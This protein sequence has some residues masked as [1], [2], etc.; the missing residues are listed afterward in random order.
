MNGLDTAQKLLFKLVEENPEDWAIR[1]RV[2]GLLE[3]SEMYEDASK[4]LWSAP[5]VPQIPVEVAYTIRVVSK[6]QPTRAVRF[7]EAIVAQYSSAPAVMVEIAKE[8]VKVGII[9]QAIRVYGAAAAVDKSVADQEFELCLIEVDSDK[10]NWNNFVN[11]EN[12]PWDA[13]VVD[14]GEVEE[15]EEEDFSALLSGGTMPVP[16]KALSA[17]IY[18]KQQPVAENK[19]PTVEAKA[20]IPE[21]KVEKKVGSE[22]ML[23]VLPD[24][25]VAKPE[26]LPVPPSEA[27]VRPK[28]EVVAERAKEEVRPQVI[29]PFKAS[30]E[31]PQ[32]ASPF[33]ASAEKPQVVSPFTASAE[34][35]VIAKSPKP[36]LSV[37]SN[38]LAQLPV[39][40]G[41]L[42]SLV[43][44]F[45][46]KSKQ[47]EADRVDVDSL[48]LSGVAP[49]PSP[50]F[51][52]VNNKIPLT[53]AA[54]SEKSPYV[55]AERRAKIS[56]SEH[57]LS[58]VST[59]IAQKV[60]RRV[61]KESNGPDVLD[62]RTQLVSLAPEDGTIFFEELA[63]KYK[64]VT[65]ANL[66]K[67][68]IIA[69]DMA[70][71]DYLD[72]VSKA[73]KKDLLAF[74]KLLGLHRVMSEANCTDWVADMNALR[75]GFGDAV[76]ATVVSKYS[77]NEC[78]EILNSVYAFP[79]SAA[80]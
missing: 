6:G 55:R 33:K 17:Q 28:P 15:E 47:V 48:D 78:K 71:L 22:T 36:N 45:R 63:L 25:V 7:V 23:K 43:N 8:L 54:T 26:L 12:F 70:N 61:T 16:I 69:R 37:V 3:E 20:V 40:S 62:G 50:S 60:E 4:M 65:S 34:K 73:C 67:P 59:A 64:N 9:H 5:D 46:G 27:Q 32:V 76:L 1:K 49:S 18:N 68:S 29:S 10:R 74:S 77:V 21:S 75:K 30:A 2:V 52:P 44:R 31:K 11:T 79:S 24:A 38:K 56:S 19:V 66:P 42:A 14:T 35:P 13:P 58:G 57:K 51:A 72:L 39:K 53:S 80:S 41:V